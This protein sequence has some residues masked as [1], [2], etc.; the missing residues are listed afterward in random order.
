MIERLIYKIRRKKKTV[1]FILGLSLFFFLLFRAATAT[2]GSSQA[3]G[4]IGATA[5]SLCHR[6][7]KGSRNQR[8]SVT[9]IIV[10]VR[11]IVG[12]RKGAPAPGVASGESWSKSS[13]VKFWL[14]VIM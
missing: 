5:V 4:L 6:S 2:N 12:G 11:A 9:A 10:P 1:H 7:W 8:S 14:L 3:K 13:R